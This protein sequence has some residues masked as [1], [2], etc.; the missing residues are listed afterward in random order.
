MFVS[1]Q[2]IFGTAPN[3]L[4]F[5]GSYKNPMQLTQ[6]KL[7]GLVCVYGSL[8][9]LVLIVIILDFWRSEWSSLSQRQ[10]STNQVTVVQ[11]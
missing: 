6:E 8:L 3:S 2:N 9:S 5:S 1:H 4:D 10:V 7:V 11:T